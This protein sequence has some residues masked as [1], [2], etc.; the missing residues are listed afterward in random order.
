MRRN[1]FLTDEQVEAEIERLTT[2]PEVRLARHEERMRYR[3]RQYMYKLRAL[4]KRGRELMAQ[5]ITAENMERV[6]FGVG[7]PEEVE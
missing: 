3:R 4:E 6:L 1:H 7:D 2:V 5:G